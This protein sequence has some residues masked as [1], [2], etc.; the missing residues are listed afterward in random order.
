MSKNISLVTGCAGFIGS[1]MTDFLLKKNHIVIGIDNLASGKMKNLKEAQKNKN[2]VFFKGNLSSIINSKKF[3]KIKK[4]DYVYH[5]AGHGELI[6]SIE[7]P[8]EY[9]KNN[10]SNTVTL[11][12]YVYK[13][14]KIKKFLYAA[15]SSCYGVVNGKANERKK[16][17]TEHPYA[18]SK[19]IGE[20]ACV[21]WSK[22]FKIPLISIRIF[23]AYGPRSR[24]TNVYGAVIGVFLKQK[25]ANYP[26]TIV[27][28]GSQ[29]RDF[30]YISDLCEAF[31]VASKSKIKFDIYNLGRG[32]AE[33]I[34]YLSS[35]ISSKKKFIPWRPGEPKYIE[36]DIS[37]IQKKLKWKPKTSLQEGMKKVLGEINYWKNAP[38]WTKS[39][40]SKATYNW[41]KFLKN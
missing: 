1:H 5:F 2:F 20:L 10:A 37:K 24:T 9:F 36:A 34:N 27:G 8:E 11:L 28:D 40:I 33:S 38:L 7:K 14:L 6:P 30:L 16:I 17:K 25:L 29:T 18:F 31:Y 15:S 39:K 13:N 26:L 4:I 21:H 41:T 23:N 12:S 22:V 3:K 35:L 32:K 19:F